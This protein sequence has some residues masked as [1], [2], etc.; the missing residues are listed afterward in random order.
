MNFCPDIIGEYQMKGDIGHGAFSTVRLCQHL[1][2]GK[3]YACK[4]VSRSRLLMHNLEMRFENEIRISQQL[5]HPGVVALYDVLKD[6]HNYYIIIEFCP[7]GELFNLVVNSGRLT[8]PEAKVFI[9]QLLY[10]LQYVHSLG[11]CHRDLKPENLLLDQNGRVKIS[12]FGLSRFVGQNGL[13]ST[14]CGSPCYASPECVSG[15]SYDGR[16]SD[17][18]SCGVITYALLTGQLPWTKRNQQQLFEQIR[19]GEY[20]IPEYLSKSCKS[21]ISGLMTVNSDYRMTIEQALHHEWLAGSIPVYYQLTMY[22]EMQNEP[23]PTPSLRKLDYIFEK[24]DAAEED[25]SDSSY[26]LTSPSISQSILS[27]KKTLLSINPQGFQS[28]AQSEVVV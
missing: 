2:T 1:E 3:F 4:I 13:V 17:I 7:N 28:V 12:D 6:E 9:C 16:K 20:T 21:F 15:Q 18:W 22:N 23:H 11:I 14:P 24:D 27:V 10:A 26:L 19:R 25:I 8:E 5:R